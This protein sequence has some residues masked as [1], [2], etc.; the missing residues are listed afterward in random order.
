MCDVSVDNQGRVWAFWWDSRNDPANNILTETW[1]ACSTDGGQTFMP[2]FV[3]TNQNFNPNVIHIFQGTQHYYLGD[4]QGMSGK[5][6]TFPFTVGNNN[7]LNDFTAYLPDYGITFDKAVDSL[8]PNGFNTNVMRFPLMGPYSGTVNI[9]QNVVPS[10]APGTLTF[11]WSGGSS[12]NLTGTP[13]AKGLTVSA[14]SNVPLGSYTVTVTGAESG[15][16]RTHARTFTVLVGNFTGVSHNTNEIPKS[17]QLFQ[18]YPNPFNPSTVIYY[19][20]PKT[21]EVNLTVYDVLGKQVQGLVNNEIKPAGEYSVKFDATNLTSGVYYYKLVAG[22][23]SD[24]RK[25]IVIK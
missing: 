6:V 7:S 24:V 20:L 1:A 8:N 5:T 4:Y 9:T 3:V 16:P 22:D 23:Y 19:S 2:N 12:I 25:M 21:S 15:G 18:N 11:T 13:G 10:P 14:S 17:Y